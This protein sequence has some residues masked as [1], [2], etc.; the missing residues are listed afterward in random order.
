MVKIPNDLFD[1]KEIRAMPPSSRASY[2]EKVIEK[3]VELNNNVGVS[4]EAIFKA[5]NFD[6][7]TISKHLE[8]LVARRIAYK[9]V[10]GN[11]VL[12]FKNGRLIHH[13]FKKDLDLNTRSFSFKALY[14]GNDILIYIQE[15]KKNPI[16]IIEEGGGI[17]VPLRDLATFS[18]YVSKIKTEVP[19]I[20]DELKNKLLEVI[21]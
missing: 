6:R 12:Y 9:V 19:T 10:Q 15:N 4:V 2:L 5:T 11:I 1:E 18:E 14:D 8:L 3:I 20:K 7:R 17:I 13:I 16:G 21:E